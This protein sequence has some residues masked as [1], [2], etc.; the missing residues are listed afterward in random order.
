MCVQTF[1]DGN[2]FSGSMCYNCNEACCEKRGVPKLRPRAF[3]AEPE[4]L[5][6][7]HL[8]T[9]DV[10][11]ATQTQAQAAGS[12]EQGRGGSGLRTAP[13]LEQVPDV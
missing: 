8:I 11:E 5:D 3:A 9:N 10:P 6:T 12:H 2:P 13:P 7:C 1:R 4:R